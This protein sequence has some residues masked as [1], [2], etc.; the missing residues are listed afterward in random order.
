VTLMRI[1]V[2]GGRFYD[3][4]SVVAFALAQLRITDVL[5][6]GGATGADELCAQWWIQHGGICDPHP[7]HWSEPCGSQCQP[8]HRRSRPDG[9]GDYCPFA[10][11]QR[12]QEM[13]DS[14]LD[15]L[16]CFP[17]GTGTNDMTSRA[18]RAGIPVWD[19]LTQ[20]VPSWASRYGASGNSGCSP[21]TG[22]GF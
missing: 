10:G 21:T 1:G 5:V 20:S 3:N 22:S 13:V 11:L 17:G 6:H 8:G 2:T 9:I 12:N 15:L 14:H 16:V 7:A 19:V 18:F 4:W